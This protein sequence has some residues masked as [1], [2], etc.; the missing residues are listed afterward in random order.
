MSLVAIMQLFK[1]SINTKSI[2]TTIRL[3]LLLEVEVEVEEGVLE[4]VL[5]LVVEASGR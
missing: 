1:Y 4:V 5:A 3:L 2:S